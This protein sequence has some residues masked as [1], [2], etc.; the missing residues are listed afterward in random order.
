METNRNIQLAKV[1]KITENRKRAFFLWS[2]MLPE[3]GRP[4]RIRRQAYTQPHGI[5]KAKPV[6]RLPFKKRSKPVKEALGWAS[7][8]ERTA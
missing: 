7:D 3:C 5:R 6:R 4:A 8:S 1:H 2:N